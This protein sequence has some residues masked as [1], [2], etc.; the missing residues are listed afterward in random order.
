MHV[1]ASLAPIVAE[2]VPGGHGVQD[3]R[4]RA[5]GWSSYVPASHG[6][7]TRRRE[8]APASGQ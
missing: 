1:D 8:S 7:K 3:E 4:L 5:P 6:V 2:A